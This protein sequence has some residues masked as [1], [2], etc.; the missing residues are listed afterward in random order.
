M[1]LFTFEASLFEAA[2][3]PQNLFSSS[4]LLPFMMLFTFEASLFEAAAPPPH[5]LFSSLPF[6]NRMKLTFVASLLEAAA[7]PFL[8]PF[9]LFSISSFF[10][11]LML[12]ALLAP[13][14]EG[15][16]EEKVEQ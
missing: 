14:L 3:P 11:K 13:E 1:M 10:F 8:L 16:V 12:L 7:P 5:H 6:F 4:S 9:L 15:K 2:A